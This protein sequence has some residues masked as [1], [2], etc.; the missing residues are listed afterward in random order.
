MKMGKTGKWMVAAGLVA[1]A[2]IGA[3][4]APVKKKGEE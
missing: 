4:V 1:A 2:A 3:I